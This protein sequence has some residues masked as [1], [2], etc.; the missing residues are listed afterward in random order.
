VTAA[1]TALVSAPAQRVGEAAY[2]TVSGWFAGR[3]VLQV[4][5]TRRTDRC[6]GCHDHGWATE[7]PVSADAAGQVTD[8]NEFARLLRTN[9]AVPVSRSAISLVIQNPHDSPVTITAIRARVES[10]TPPAA[11]TLLAP[12]GAGGPGSEVLRL[13]FDLDEPDHR[14]RT[15]TFDQSGREVAGE[16]YFGRHFLPIGPGEQI[17][18]MLQAKTSTCLCRWA[19][20]AAVV[21][22]GHAST[23]PL[24]GQRS[25][26]AVTA[27]AE[28]YQNGYRYE[29]LADAGWEVAPADLAQLCPTNCGADLDNLAA[30]VLSGG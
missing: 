16:V 12:S 8:R 19:A 5:E 11:G 20:E 10:R 6:F 25:P 28:R 4:T 23:V 3:P 26:Y 7:Q 14:A 24:G 1:L 18:I 21:L 2:D 27:A 13:I 9:A 29:A 17:V 15:L 30:V 22:D